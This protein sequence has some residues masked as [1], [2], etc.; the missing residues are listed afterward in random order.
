MWVRDAN[1]G[2]RRRSTYDVFIKIGTIQ[3]DLLQVSANPRDNILIGR[4]LI[5]LWN[6][7][8]DGQTQ[9]GELI[10][11]STDPNDVR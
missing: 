3:F 4:D 11:W 7:K 2:R 6:L 10:P 1:G 9:T 5:N 8:L